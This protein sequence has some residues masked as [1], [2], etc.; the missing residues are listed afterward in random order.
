MVVP[1]I[2]DRDGRGGP[3]E[4]RGALGSRVLVAAA[5]ADGPHANLCPGIRITFRNM[6]LQKHPLTTR[7]LTCESKYLTVQS[8]AT[9]HA[10]SPTERGAEWAQ[11]SSAR[12]ACALMVGQLLLP[13]VALAADWVNVGGTQYNRGTAAGDEAGTRLGRWRR[14]EAQRLRR[15]RHQ[16]SGQPQYRRDG[17]QH[18]NGRFLAERY[19][20]QGTATLPSRGRGTLSATAEPQKSRSAVKVE[21]GSLAISGDVTLNATAGTDTIAVSGDGKTGGDVGHPRCQR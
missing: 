10:R 9:A 13:S 14:H 21:C 16:C 20:G 8:T 4:R 18:R 12:G 6:V 2:V 19:R 1:S 7:R 17:H 5:L 3:F 15:R 11:N